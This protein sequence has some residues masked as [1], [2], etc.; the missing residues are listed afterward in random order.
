MSELKSLLNEFNIS[1]SD[2]EEMNDDDKISKDR[3]EIDFDNDE[4]DGVDFDE[5]DG[6][7]DNTEEDFGEEEG[8]FAGE[9]RVDIT[10]KLKA[11]LQRRGEEDGDESENSGQEELPSLDHLDLDDT[12]SELEA[13][14]DDDL[15]FDYNAF[16]NDQ[17]ISHDS[18]DEESEFDFSGFSR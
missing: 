10:N 3:G 13:D 8:E 16:K 12:D 14:D 17:E 7:N 1:V 6:E 11:M 18:D 5:F 2:E 15:D 4:K 9:K